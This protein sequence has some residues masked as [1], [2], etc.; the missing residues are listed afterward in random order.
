MQ[1]QAYST[2]TG[3]DHTY[4]QIHGAL[5]MLKGARSVKPWHGP[6]LRP[7]SG[8]AAHCDLHN[9]DLHTMLHSDLACMLQQGRRLASSHAS[10]LSHAPVTRAWHPQRTARGL[11]GPVLGILLH[12][13]GVQS[14]NVEHTFQH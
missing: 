11:V 10:M 5:E 3:L 9:A 2:R 12:A 4:N 8:H 6:I 7:C 13:D 1:S 14:P